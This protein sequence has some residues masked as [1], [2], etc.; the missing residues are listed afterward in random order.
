MATATIMMV[1]ITIA[2]IAP[3]EIVIN[4]Y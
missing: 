1:A 3:S 2:A 4:Y